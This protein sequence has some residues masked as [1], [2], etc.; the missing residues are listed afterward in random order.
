[1]FPL[2]KNSK[3]LP[4]SQALKAMVANGNSA[5]VRI[6]ALVEGAEER[7]FYLFMILFSLPFVS[8]IPLPAL[9]NVFGV[10]ATL[11]SCRLA[12]RRAS[13]ARVKLR[14][15]SRPKPSVSNAR[16]S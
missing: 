1:M 15:L 13:F 2:N 12:F 3:H 10:V 9:S 14:P 6:G 7:G 5:T 4:L 16:L 8:P 11:I